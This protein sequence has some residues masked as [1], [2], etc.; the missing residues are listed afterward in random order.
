[1]ALL[2]YS[3]AVKD[4]VGAAA[5]HALSK[6]HDS[7]AVSIEDII[8]GLNVHRRQNGG[9]RID[10]M[11]DVLTR[12]S[13]APWLI[14]RAFVSADTLAARDSHEISDL[15]LQTE[16]ESALMHA[17]GLCS[18]TTAHPGLYSL[19][20]HY[21]PLYLQWARVRAA[22]PSLRIPRYAYAFGS[23][24]PDV[25]GF[26]QIIY[27]SAYDLRTWKPNS[28]PAFWWHTFAV[29]R[30]EGQP[31]VASVIDDTVL[32]RDKIGPVAG[33]MIL[34]VSSGICR[35]FG[36]IFGEILYFVAGDSVTFAAFS[37]SM[38]TDV[39]SSEID[40]L[41]EGWLSREFPAMTA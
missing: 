21:L 8:A 38:A 39:P 14:N 10:G 28:P 12:I 25:S 34:A 11:A 24:A 17:I 9:Y 23:V 20:G 33:E 37:H 41:L 3:K 2:L 22:C 15:S 5:L 7:G 6:R 32:V 30:P 19:C 1:M 18:R 36:S 16:V 26:S 13:E 35:E 27:K 29:E 31:V 4:V 40:Q